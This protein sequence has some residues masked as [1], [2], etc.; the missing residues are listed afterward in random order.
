MLSG[1]GGGSVDVF[2]M[3]FR[4]SFLCLFCQYDF[5]YIPRPVPSRGSIVF[6]LTLQHDSNLQST[7]WW[8][9][10]STSRTSLTCM[11]L[12]TSWYYH[13]I[14]GP[15]NVHSLVAACSVPSYFH[16][17][18]WTVFAVYLW[19]SPLVLFPFL[20]LLEMRETLS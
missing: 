20:D 6:P 2:R 13:D 18:S 7:G 11:S 3:V 9:R 12:I 15:W 1:M 17:I 8:W 5:F 4:N 16:R 10:C 19:K 14:Y